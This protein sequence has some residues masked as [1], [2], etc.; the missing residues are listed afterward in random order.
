MPVGAL[1]RSR[2]AAC[3]LCRAPKS[4]FESAGALAEKLGGRRCV[5]GPCIGVLIDE[6]GV[7]GM[8]GVRVRAL[9][10]ASDGCR[11]RGDIDGELL[12]AFRWNLLGRAVSN[13]P[14]SQVAEALAAR[15]RL[16]RIRM[17]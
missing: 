8:A 3:G 13:G 10:I 4:W 1:V 12:H 5:S 17:S 14:G 7:Y 16:V 15:L 6:G 2:K 11:R 9:L